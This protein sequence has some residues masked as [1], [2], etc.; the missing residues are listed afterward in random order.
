MNNAQPTKIW[1]VQKKKSGGTVRVE[2][3]EVIL[4]HGEAFSIRNLTAFKAHFDFG[5]YIESPNNGDIDPGGKSANF[6]VR[7]SAPPYFEYEVTLPV[8]GVDAVGGS[9]PGVIIDP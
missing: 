2:P 3:P 1:V 5:G 4:A 6:K 9:K 8:E 7:D